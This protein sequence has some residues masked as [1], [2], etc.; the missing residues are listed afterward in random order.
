M[1][2]KN[3]ATGQVYPITDA[4]W[5]NLGRSGLQSKFQIVDE[6]VEKV[7]AKE[8]FIPKEIQERNKKISEK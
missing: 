4:E 2:V 6:L 7:K 1:I 5:E 8:P 3:T